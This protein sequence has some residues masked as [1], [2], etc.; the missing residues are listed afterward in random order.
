MDTNKNFFLSRE[1]LV[2]V[3]AAT[4]VFILH[5]AVGLGALWPVVA[6]SAWGAGV[7]LTPTSEK[8]ALLSATTRPAEEILADRLHQSMDALYAAHP[9]RVVRDAAKELDVNSTFVLAEWHE[10]ETVPSK[11]QTMYDIIDVYLPEVVKLYTDHPDRSLPSAV[12]GT[13]DSLRTLS[14]AVESIKQA[15]IENNVRMIDGNA[16]I[17]RQRFGNLPGLSTSIDD[18]T[19]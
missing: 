10:L 17:L 3:V 7:F 4:L 9:P 8:K 5:L 12:E 1:N 11:Q 19:N 14:G 6:V 2:G 16:R 18:L 15:I 13:I